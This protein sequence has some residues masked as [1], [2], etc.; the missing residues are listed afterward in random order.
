MKYF[1]T[2][3]KE[4]IK[5]EK[6]I[7]LSQEFHASI[8]ELM[9]LANKQLQETPEQKFER[10]FHELIV[11]EIEKG[12]NAAQEFINMI[13]G[14]HEYTYIN[15]NFPLS[16]YETLTEE[17]LLLL[18]QSSIY[19]GKNSELRKATIRIVFHF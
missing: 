13:P 16:I 14:Y 7:E 11:K 9:G 4:D 8:P 15:N 17:T 12:V 10:N 5:M 6:K 1:F 19:L 3:I 18:E 2:E